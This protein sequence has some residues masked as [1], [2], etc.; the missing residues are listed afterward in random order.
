MMYTNRMYS[1]L[2]ASSTD[3]S[4][5]TC[6]NMYIYTPVSNNQSVRST[7]ADQEKCTVSHQGSSTIE[8]YA[9]TSTKAAIVCAFPQCKEIKSSGSFSCLLDLIICLPYKGLGFRV[10]GLDANKPVFIAS[11]PPF[12]PIRVLTGLNNHAFSI[13]RSLPSSDVVSKNKN[14]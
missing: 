9:G 5:V 11:C 3:R 6:Q 8:N 7:L 13:G 10:L 12:W 2:F 1:K 4:K 14:G